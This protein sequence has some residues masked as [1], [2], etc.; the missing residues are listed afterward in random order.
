MYLY[1]N[2]E[3]GN[4]TTKEANELVWEP[5]LGYYIKWEDR[6]LIYLDEDIENLEKYQLI[7][8]IER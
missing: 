1:T 5:E 4:I 3:T 7:E 2:I 6:K 8:S